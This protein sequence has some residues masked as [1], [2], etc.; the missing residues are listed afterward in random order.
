MRYKIIIRILGFITMF[1]GASMLLSLPFS[2]YY[3]SNDIIPISLSAAITMVIGALGFFLFKSKQEVRPKEGFMIVALGWIVFSALGSLPY[4]LGNYIPPFTDAFFETMSGFTTT[5]ATILTDIEI[6]PEGILFWRSFTHWLGGM[7]IIVLGIAILPL[8]GVGGMQLFKAE[9]PGPI[10]DK[11]TPR[12]TETA[13]ILWIVYVLLTAIETALLMIGGMNLHQSLCHTFG[14]MAT[15]GYSTLNKSV[16]GFDS[17]YID[18][19]IIIFMIL[20]GMNFSLHYRML[21]GNVK[22]MFINRESQFYF[23][24]IG[25]ATLV[26]GIDTYINNYS[27]ILETLRYT[28]FQVVSI[29]TTTGFGTADYEQWSISSQLVLFLLMFIGGMAGSTGGGMKV[30]RIYLLFK[31]VYAE[32][33]RLVHPQ[34]IVPVRMGNITVNRDVMMNVLGFFVLYMLIAAFSSLYLSFYEIDIATS[35]GAVAAT[36]NNIGPGLELVGPTDNYAF[37]PSP[38]KWHLSF[39]MLLGRLEVYTVVI[40][41]A[42]SFWQK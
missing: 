27:S 40:L 29:I 16:G 8:L 38:V 5:G 7:G 32:I 30:M 23:A 6:L 17:A 37:L 15:G 1:L 22:E 21:K 31:F 39:L 2:F 34:A 9:V 41:L 10:A 35:I 28:L 18:Y 13:K 36:L 24:I 19:V 3:G 26:I 33:V 11:L 25:F 42:P 4:M 20:A 12:V 14:T